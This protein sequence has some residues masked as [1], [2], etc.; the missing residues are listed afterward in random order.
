M[1][2]PEAGTPNRFPSGKYAQ[3]VHDMTG[4]W[5]LYKRFAGGWISAVG[6]FRGKTM[7]KANEP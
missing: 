4:V 3:K 1:K 6:R 7:K 5:P 2:R